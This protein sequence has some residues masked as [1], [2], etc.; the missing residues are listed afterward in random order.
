[1]LNKL[2]VKYQHQLLTIHFLLHLPKQ[3]I[4]ENESPQKFRATLQTEHTQRMINEFPDDTVSSE[5][6]ITSFDA[7]ETIFTTTP[8]KSLKI[9]TATKGRRNEISFNKKWFDKKVSQ[10]TRPTKTSQ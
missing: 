3:I 2:N 4:W 5:N 9:K 8:K 1:M 6:V 7:V 10:E